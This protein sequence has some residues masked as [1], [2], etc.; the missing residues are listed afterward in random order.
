MSGSDTPTT[1]ITGVRTIGVPVRDQGKALEFYTTVLGFS[2]RLDVP[3]PQGT[4]WIEVGPS[5]GGPSIALVQEHDGVP[6]GIETGIRLTT[7]DADADHAALLARGVDAGE[8]LRWPGV[9]AMFS[10]RDQDGNGLELV[11][12]P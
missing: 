8:V 2:K 4:R 1:H 3:T 10:F 6:A 12:Q 5:S 7:A 9:P 11:Q